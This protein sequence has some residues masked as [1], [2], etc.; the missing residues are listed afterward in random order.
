MMTTGYFLNSFL[1]S[2]ILF[3]FYFC[4]KQPVKQNDNFET[5]IFQLPSTFF[6]C[7]NYKQIEKWLECICSKI[8][9]EFLSK[10]YLLIIH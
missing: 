3:L 1:E 2:N 9:C 6:S 4:K 7:V 10:Q 8:V 5:I